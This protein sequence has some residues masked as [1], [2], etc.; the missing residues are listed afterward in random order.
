MKYKYFL[1]ARKSSEGD[2]RQVQSIGDQTDHITKLAKDM[3]LEIVEILSE[4]KSAKKP[5]NR[6]VFD[7]MLRR[8]EA[9]EADSILC[10][11][12]NRLSRNPIDSGKIQWLLQQGII[13]SIRTIS[14]EYKPDDNALLLNIESG[15]ANQF[16]LELKKGVKRGIDSK[17]N[18]GLAPLLAPLGYLNTKIE[19][20]GENY[21]VKDPARLLI[22][23]KMWDLMLTGSYSVPQVRDIATKEWGL[24]TPK[25]K[26]RGGGPI[27]YT[28]A[29]NIFSNIFYTG[30]FMYRGQR[31]KGYHE[32]IITL[33]EFDRVQTLIGARGN[34]RPKTH[35]FAYGCGTFTCGECG[36][37][38]TSIEKIKY[39]KSKQETKVYV[40][41]LCGN[42]GKV[43]TC[44]QD[45]NVNE[46]E[47]EKQLK[48]ELIKYTI[49][50]EFLHWALEVMKDNEIIGMLTEKD[51]KENVTK[52]LEN[53]QE[54][55]KRLIQMATKGFISDE[56]FKQSRAELDEVILSLKSQ[57]EEV[58][59]EKNENLMR[60]TE[61]AFIFSTY[62]LMALENGDKKTKNEI[63]K[64][65]GLNRT[66]KD[67]ILNIRAFEWYMEV[68]K[69]YTE[70]RKILA[71]AEPGLSCKQTIVSDFPNI[72]S[73]LRGRWVLTPRPL[74]CTNS[75]F[76]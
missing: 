66:I 22:V 44:S 60:L 41:Y 35:T 13:K 21:I 50:P 5:Y 76:S 38:L 71:L 28:S 52:T 18:K 34:P 32:P 39:L 8:I 64:S 62:A 24:L 19:A 49:D 30:Y 54:E 36:Y 23:R 10:W 2:D 29:Y 65:F 67:K 12:I 53:K 75:L 74:P 3:G 51:I 58:E 72:R 9:G 20:K 26:K 46:V 17:L 25:R 68:R 4:A 73:V 47:I 14:R 56:E 31:Y 6:P 11:E 70:L 1:Y 55:L 27:A 59:S 40:F 43:T 7:E 63:V 33:A 42:R 15:S 61:K 57:L 48:E 37:S 69:G 16:I 45:Y